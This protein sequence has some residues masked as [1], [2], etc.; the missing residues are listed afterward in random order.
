MIGGSSFGL[1][2]QW[3]TGEPHWP[4]HP[5]IVIW[6]EMKMKICHMFS[7]AVGH[8]WATHPSPCGGIVI[9]EARNI[10]AGPNVEQIFAWIKS[11]IS[12]WRQRWALSYLRF[13]DFPPT[14]LPIDPSK[15]LPHSTSPA[16]DYFTPILCPKLV[17]SSSKVLGS[18]ITRK[19]AGEW[20]T[21][22]VNATFCERQNTRKINEGI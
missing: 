15:V 16:R 1:A 2:Q 18:I 17:Q 9:Y 20:Y 14:F 22:I 13:R 11:R 3:D 4:T 6:N 19:P 12:N 8:R 5:G 7:T 10:F 21:N